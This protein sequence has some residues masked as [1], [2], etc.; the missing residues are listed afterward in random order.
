MNDD[1]TSSVCQG[2]DGG[3]GSKGDNGDPGKPVRHSFHSHVKTVSLLRVS[4]VMLFIC[5]DSGTSRSLR[6]AWT[7]GKTRT[8]GECVSDESHIIN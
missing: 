6:R 5:A 4:Y 3:A 1:D 2:I 7:T 8:A